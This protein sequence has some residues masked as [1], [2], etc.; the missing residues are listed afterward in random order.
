MSNKIVQIGKD[1]KGSLT[2][3]DI[4]TVGTSYD[5]SK[6][7]EHPI[8][9]SE[10]S[11]GYDVPYG[12]CLGVWVEVD[13]ISTASKLSVYISSD[14]NGDVPNLTT[15]EINIDT[16][17][18]TSTKGTVQVF[19]GMPF[20]IGQNTP[21]LYMFFKTNTGTVTIKKSQITWRI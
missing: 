12:E 21:I 10:S 8:G 1:I 17:V 15:D 11:L 7:H 6:K 19:F 13:T 18:T 14:A 4:E 16:G 9:R 5:T 2:T 3:E 20:Y